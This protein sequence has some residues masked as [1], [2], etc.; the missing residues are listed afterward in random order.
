[1]FQGGLSSVKGYEDMRPKQQ[2]KYG[3]VGLRQNHVLFDKT[4]K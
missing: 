2:L 1:M 4:K 3:L